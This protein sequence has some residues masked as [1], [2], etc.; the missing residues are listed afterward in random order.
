MDNGFKKYSYLHNKLIELVYEP[1][2]FE[3]N[4]AIHFNK[5]KKKHK[6][7]IILIYVHSFTM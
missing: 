6:D 2:W 5:K 1:F 7:L 3:V 4:E